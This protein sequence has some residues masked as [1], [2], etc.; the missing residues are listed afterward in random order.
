MELP[1]FYLHN[2]KCF[3]QKDNIYTIPNALSLSRIV[4]SPVIA[5][6]VLNGQH[7]VALALFSVAGITDFVSL[8]ADILYLT[9]F[10][11]ILKL[12]FRSK[13]SLK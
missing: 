3:F 13:S 6:T 7:S 11:E 1:I 8:M 5:Y 9:S 2:V 12:D 10:L 4:M